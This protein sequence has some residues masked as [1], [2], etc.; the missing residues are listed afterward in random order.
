MTGKQ[1]RNVIQRRCYAKKRRLGKCAYCGKTPLYKDTVACK[2]CRKIRLHY[3]G[4][5]YQGL[6]DIGLCAQ[7]GKREPRPGRSDCVACFNRRTAKQ[8]ALNQSRIDNGLCVRGCGRAIADGSA[9][10]CKK[11]WDEQRAYARKAKAKARVA[12]CADCGVVLE[13]RTWK[14]C[15]ACGVARLEKKGVF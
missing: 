7:C 2:D 5:R 10:F 8:N 15:E 12:K 9:R 3:A 1:P 6:R 13:D 11:H 4:K 14:R